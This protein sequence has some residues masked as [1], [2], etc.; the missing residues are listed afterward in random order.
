MPLLQINVLMVIPEIICAHARE[1]TLG[2]SPV[3][4]FLVIIHAPQFGDSSGQAARSY[5]KQSSC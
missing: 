1:E 4:H 3:W 2:E 5:I